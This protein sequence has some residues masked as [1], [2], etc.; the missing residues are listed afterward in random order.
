MANLVTL[1]DVSR[2]FSGAAGERTVWEGLSL[3]IRRGELVSIF[4]PNGSGKTTLL[5]II[6]GLDDGYAGACERAPDMNVSYVY[7]HYRQSN[8]PWLSVADN[9]A[10]PLKMRGASVE[11]CRSAV[12][13]LLARFDMPLDLAAYPYQLS[14]GQQQLVALMRALVTKPDVLLLDEPF[15]ALDYEMTL[16]FIEKLREIWRSLGVS[17]VCVSHDIETTLLLGQRILI[18]GKNPSHIAADMSGH[19]TVSQQ[20]HAPYSAQYLETRNKVLDTFM[21]TVPVGRFVHA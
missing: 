13:E 6:A 7:Q 15:S 11:E 19:D 4:G 9:I 8:F 16:Y 5:N 10:L 21:P 14:G 20:L 3:D 12:T 2:S 1:R 17:I 18:L